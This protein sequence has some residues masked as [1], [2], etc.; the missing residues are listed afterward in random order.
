MLNTSIKF[1]TAMIRQLV[2]SSRQLGSMERLKLVCL[3]RCLIFVQ[4]CERILGTIMMRI[5]VCIDGL[6]LQP[7]NGVKLL[8]GRRA[9]ACERA[10]HCSL[11]LCNL[12]VLYCVHK[13]V[14]CL[15]CM[16]LQLLRR[17]LL[18]KRSDFVEVHLE[19]MRH[20]LRKFIL[21]S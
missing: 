9:K 5:I 21:G 16:V 10:E 13:C 18:T 12:R 17:V 20:L 4:V 11:N 8:D 7:G 2:D 15:S 14:L 1:T 3:Y 6:G 19:I